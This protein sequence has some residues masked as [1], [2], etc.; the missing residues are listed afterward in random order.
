MKTKFIEIGEKVSNKGLYFYQILR[1]KKIVIISNELI[2]FFKLKRKKPPVK[3]I[4][5]SNVLEKRLISSSLINTFYLLNFTFHPTKKG[6]GR[7]ETKY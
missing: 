4:I 2:S 6:R 1:N 7:K 5:Q 3:E